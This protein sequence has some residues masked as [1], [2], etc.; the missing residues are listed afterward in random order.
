MTKYRKYAKISRGDFVE[1][2]IG[3][4]LVAVIMLCLGFSLVDV[5]MFLVWI[6]A[7]V[8]V[9]TALFFTVC[10]F[11]LITAKPAKA[12]FLR[13]DDTKRFP[14]A[15]YRVDGEERRN[16]FPG[17]TVMK[18]KLYIEGKKKR[19]L[20]SRIFRFVIDGNALATII[21]GVCVSIPSAFATIMWAIDFIG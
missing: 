9:L 2:V 14:A 21:L 6:L 10:L 3:F 8:I 12:E 1:Y 20:K 7:A 5:G 17:E 11:F 19:V 15:V 4:G 18:K 16:I 13:L